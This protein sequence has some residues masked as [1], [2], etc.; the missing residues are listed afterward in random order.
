VNVVRRLGILLGLALAA[1]PALAQ[2][3]P[4]VG[5]LAF[6]DLTQDFRD[7][8][9]RGLLAEGYVEGRNIRIEWRS[10]N[11]RADRAA[12]IAAEFVELK[13]DVI[14]ASL[15]AAVQAARKATRSIPIVMAPAG[16]PIQ[17][18][19]ASSLARPGGN[20]TGLTGVELSAKRV[21]LL[22]ELAPGLKRVALLLNR[23]DPTFAGVMLRGTETADRQFGIETRAYTIEGVEGFEQAFAAMAGEAAGAVV[24]QP[25]LMPTSGAM[26]RAARLALRHRIPAM[27]QQ[28]Q[29]VAQGG[30]ISYGIDFR[31]QYERAAS[32]VARILKKGEKPE[33]MP[34][35]Q[36]TSFELV[37]NSKTATALGIAIPQSV[38]LRAT[39]VVD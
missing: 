6:T 16:D 19:F 39:R 18:G 30:L 22:R 26:T 25:S 29:F 36:A 20:V 11:G 3:T 34:I 10:A 2:P 28:A 35:E 1:C 37:V 17:Q 4:R 32:Y 5:V 33:A 24:I 31:A 7:A 21:E 38:L 15:S 9:G 23:A 12:R 27:T 14:V 8:F 13:V